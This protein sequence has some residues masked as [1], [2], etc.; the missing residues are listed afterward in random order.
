[1]EEKAEGVSL[2]STVNDSE[3]TGWLNTNLVDLKDP[4]SCY[5]YIFTLESELTKTYRQELELIVMF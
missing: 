2:M 4:H 5:Q 1:M 3:F